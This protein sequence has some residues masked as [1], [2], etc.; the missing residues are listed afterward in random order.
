M[1][2]EVAQGGTDPHGGEYELP[3]LLVLQRSGLFDGAW[4]L[5]RNP[6]LNLPGTDP[7]GHFHRYG[8][9]EG[10][11]PNAYFDPTWY[12][13]RNTDVRDS[14]V[15]PVLHYI[16]HGEAEGR[17]PVEHFD[18]A[19][20]RLQHA[21]PAGTLA[22]AHFLQHRAG[23]AVSPIPEFD[24]AHYLR[25]YPD[26]A[27]AGM[28]PFEHYLVQGAAEDREP[29]AA[30]DP[31]FYRARYLR[32]HPE[33]VPLL[34]YCSHKGQPGIHPRQPEAD[35]DI[36]SEVRRNT[37]P[38]PLFEERQPLPPGARPRATVLAFYLPQFHAV[39]ENDAWWGKGFTEWTNVGRA[40]P[41]F[42]GH[43][44]PRTPRD[45]GHYTLRGTDVLR[46]QADMAR[47]AGIGGFVFTCTRSTAAACW[48]GR[49][50]PCWPTPR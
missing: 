16:L 39:P 23:G 42:A 13:A 2:P 12:L 32:Q 38:G 6:D 30:F 47:G 1:I 46:Q 41:R 27:A 19:W 15:N 35:T 43:Y 7:L 9:R 14:G 21:V 44:Q 49:W 5:A 31:V 28:D 50:K 17:P 10:R 3:A 25:R 26:V 40:L 29:S 45:L 4:F 48:T 11:W 37:R 33:A 20:Y 36:P 22:L 18:P 8:W 24:A 34:H